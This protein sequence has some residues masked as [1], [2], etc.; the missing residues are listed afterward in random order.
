MT[1]LVA[2]HVGSHTILISDRFTF[3]RDGQIGHRNYRKLNQSENHASIG[4]GCSHVLFESSEFL[5]GKTLTGEVELR[6]LSKHLMD[7]VFKHVG[8]NLYGDI[9][10]LFVSATIEAE[11]KLFTV[12]HDGF[13]TGGRLKQSTDHESGE[14]LFAIPRVLTPE[15]GDS[16]KREATALI[17][18]FMAVKG[19]GLKPSDVGTVAGLA[20]SVGAALN[21]L[22]HENEFISKDYDVSILSST[23]L[24]YTGRIDFDAKRAVTLVQKR[25]QEVENDLSEFCI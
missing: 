19:K 16:F 1:I 10:V 7:G 17:D 24:T 18:E 4:A 3:K 14:I 5:N 12:I 11:A 15:Q 21:R 6:G 23:G 13:K 2:M 20:K 22:A 9:S 8:E 25:E